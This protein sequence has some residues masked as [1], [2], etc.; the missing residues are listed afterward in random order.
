MKLI[1]DFPASVAHTL[2]AVAA[3]CIV[4]FGAFYL[5]PIVPVWADALVAGLLASGYYMLHEYLDYRKPDHKGY[6][7][8]AWLMPSFAAAST[9]V[10]L[11]WVFT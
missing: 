7:L 4:F 5:L 1:E 10:I 6:G 11:F 2:V 9:A 3:V 8:Q